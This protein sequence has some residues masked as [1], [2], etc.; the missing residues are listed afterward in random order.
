MCDWN[1]NK[2]K[3]Y[4]L[5]YYSYKSVFCSCPSYYIVWYNYLGWHVSTYFQK[6]Q[7]LQNKA[8]RGISGSH[9]QAE[10]NPIYHQLK[11]LKIKDLYKYEVTQF[12]FSCLKNKAQNFFS[13][14]FTRTNQV[15]SRH[16]RQ[17]LRNN[18]LYIARYCSNKLQRCMKYQGVKIREQILNESYISPIIPLKADTNSFLYHLTPIQNICTRFRFVLIVYRS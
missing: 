17:S 1:T 7:I 18:K 6:L 3:I 10:T 9:Y 12:V 14:Y 4:F 16:T 11:V 8:L 2:T 5:K 15:S 13:K